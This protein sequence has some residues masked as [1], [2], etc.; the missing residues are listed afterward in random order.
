MMMARLP[1]F[2]AVAALA[3]MTAGYIFQVRNQ[4]EL[5][6]MA[7]PETV[8]ALKVLRAAEPDAGII[9]NSFTLAL[10][11]SA[12]NK[13]QS[14]HTWTTEPPK[15]FVQTDINV[16]CVL[17]WI[18]REKGCIPLESAQA[19]QAGYVLIEGRFPFYNS[20]APAV[21]GSPNPEDPWGEL[22]SLPWLKPVYQRG[23]TKVYQIA[24]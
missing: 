1:M 4:A 20:R 11:I 13:V 3:L 2:L 9:T 16:R 8:S 19:L 7:T 12:L 21:Y 10:W 22:A 24:Y 5:S 23:T 18:P 15:R 14:P 6:A 17:G